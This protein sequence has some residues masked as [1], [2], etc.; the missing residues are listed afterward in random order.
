M[1]GA[2]GGGRGEQDALVRLQGQVGGGRRLKEEP[3]RAALKTRL[4]KCVNSTPKG[5]SE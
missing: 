4:K 3:P 5:Q 1:G 2:C